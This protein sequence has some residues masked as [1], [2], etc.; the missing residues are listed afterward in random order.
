VGCPVSTPL[1]LIVFHTQVLLG[2]ATIGQALIAV[3]SESYVEFAKAVWKLN[4][5]YKVRALSDSG[6]VDLGT[7]SAWTPGP[8]LHVGAQDRLPG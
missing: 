3:M 4:K 5:S 1:K 7:E 8:D 6:S 2:D